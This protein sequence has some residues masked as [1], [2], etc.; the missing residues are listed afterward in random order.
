MSKQQ[1]TYLLLIAVLGIWGVIGYQLI[2]KLYPSD[3]ANN[4][5]DSVQK[6]KPK[7]FE[8]RK[9][10]TINGQYRDPFLGTLHT[11]KKKKP[12][13]KVVVKKME[14]VPFPSIVYNGI[15]EGATTSYTISVNGKQELFTLGETINKVTLVKADTKKIIVRFGNTSKTFSLQ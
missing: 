4:K 5:P 13:R 11:Q 3:S 7:K 6:F 15:V 12:K 1:K 14:N 9:V 8:K 2:A 10:Y